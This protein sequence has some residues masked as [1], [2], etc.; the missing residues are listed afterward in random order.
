MKFLLLL[1]I[2]SVVVNTHTVALIM[3]TT[4]AIVSSNLRVTL[5]YN[6]KINSNTILIRLTFN[7]V[8]NRKKNSL[9]NGWIISL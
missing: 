7:T 3:N 9:S 2:N 5:T 1:F 4:T 6:S 8:I